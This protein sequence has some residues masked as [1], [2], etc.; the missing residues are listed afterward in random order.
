M[1]PDE[2]VRALIKSGAL[3][4]QAGKKVLEAVAAE[5]RPGARWELQ[6]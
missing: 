4:E 1:K 3:S 5:R 6:L 2:R